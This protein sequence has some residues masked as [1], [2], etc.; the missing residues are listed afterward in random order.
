MDGCRV[1]ASVQV[2]AAC[3]P[4]YISEFIDQLHCKKKGMIPLVLEAV[5]VKAILDRM[6]LAQEW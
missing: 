3:E 1:Q 6:Q 4:L 2:W 5:E